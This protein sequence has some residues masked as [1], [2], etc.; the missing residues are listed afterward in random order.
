MHITVGAAGGALDDFYPAVYNNSW[1]ARYL[2][3]VFG[4]G[5]INI[6]N[7]TA[8]NFQFIGHDDGAVLDDVWVFRE[9]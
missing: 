5:Q 9:R 7:D 6:A 1:T 8:L 4:Y 3:G 2:R